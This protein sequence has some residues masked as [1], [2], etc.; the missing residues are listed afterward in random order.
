M[1][2]VSPYRKE[3]L[4]HELKENAARFLE[5]ESNRTSLITVTN[6]HL[7]KDFRSAI[8]FFTVLPEDQEEVAVAFIK[9]QQKHFKDYMRKHSSIGRVPSCDF[10]L[11][12]G[13]K[14]RQY[15]DKKL[16]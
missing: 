3:R 8:I 1:H 6:V 16:S 9:R 12:T 10:R 11:D 14:N 4:S 5:L 15:V 7:S 13:E 2:P